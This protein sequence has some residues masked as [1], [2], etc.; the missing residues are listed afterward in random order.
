M[1]EA[2]SS[3]CSGHVPPTVVRTLQVSATLHQAPA[4]TA[5]PHN[6]NRRRRLQASFYLLEAM[7][8]QTSNRHNGRIT[9]C[10]RGADALP[11]GVSAALPHLCS[12]MDALVRR[13]PWRQSWGY[14][15]TSARERS[16]RHLRAA[17]VMRAGQRGPSSEA[18]VAA[19]CSHADAAR[20]V[21]AIP[22]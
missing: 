6:T 12:T 11:A 20:T 9:H 3:S 13:P 19:P 15:L 10:Q 8:S 21:H 7:A 4:D 22:I 2:S 18:L 17:N 5:S 14:Q 16:D 1:P